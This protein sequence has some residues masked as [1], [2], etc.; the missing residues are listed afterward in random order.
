MSAKVEIC[1]IC[2]ER[3]ANSN[4]HFH[5]R[6]DLKQFFG[7]VSLKR[8]IVKYDYS[9]KRLKELKSDK[10]KDLT[11]KRKICNYCNN[12][13]T[14][15]YDQAW[16]TLSSYLSRRHNY[17]HKNKWLYTNAVFNI[18]P[19]EGMLFI[20]LYFLKIFGCHVKDNNFSGID[21]NEISHNLLMGYYNPYFLIRFG[22]NP[23]FRITHKQS[24]KYPLTVY[25]SKKTNENIKGIAH[26][27]YSIGPLVI[28]LL[29]CRNKN[30]RQKYFNFHYWNPGESINTH[31]IRYYKN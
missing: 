15:K 28:D 27:V 26:T 9:T 20:H 10:S 7:E 5:K 1:W 12:T 19:N 23:N 3:K 16:R 17:S 21:L 6:S 24:M 31:K 2:N 30:Q 13:L 11:F 25:V 29:Y 4:E 14:Q 22:F 8:P 18:N